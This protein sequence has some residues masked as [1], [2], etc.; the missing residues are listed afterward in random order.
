MTGYVEALFDLGV[1]IVPFYLY[2]RTPFQ[3]PTPFRLVDQGRIALIFE[4]KA[5]NKPSKIRLGD[6]P[7]PHPG[8][9]RSLEVSIHI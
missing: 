5:K 1:H 8:P 6:P 7:P 2:T 4:R 9:I 3:P